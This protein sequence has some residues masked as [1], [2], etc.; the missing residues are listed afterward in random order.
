MIR[1]PP[2]STL[3]PYTT[4]FR[5]ERLVGA[6]RFQELLAPGARIYYETHYRPLLEMQ[7]AVREIAVEI[8]AADGR[9]LPVLINSTLQREAGTIRTTVFEAGDRR[10]YE[11]ELLAQRRRAEEA[12]EHHQD[13]AHVLQ[14]SILAGDL[15]QDPR[16]EIGRASCRERV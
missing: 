8:V 10:R 3:F 7:G 12:S 15:P 5:S 11:Q 14:Q 4:L 16:L 1:R 13:V 6:R 2:R 9:R